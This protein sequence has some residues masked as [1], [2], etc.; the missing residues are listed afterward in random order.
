MG[1]FNSNRHSCALLIFLLISMFSAGAW[2]ATPAGTVIRNPALATYTDSDGL[3]RSVTSN[4]VETLVEQVAGMELTSDQQQRRSPGSTVR[5]SHRVRNTGNADDRF[6]LSVSNVGG[7]V[8]LQSLALFADVDGDGVADNQTP[9]A[10]TPFIA[11]GGD[12]FVVVEGQVPASAI[13][14][15]SALIEIAATSEFD[16]ATT[17]QNLDTVTVGVGPAIAVAKTL[18][19]TNGLSPSGPY[20]VTLNYENTGDEAAGDV[21]L[22]DALPPGMTYVPGSARWSAFTPAL[23]DSDPTDLHVGSNGSLRYCAYDASCTG[24][25]EAQLDSDTDSSN[26]VTAIIDL[27]DAGVSGSVTFDVTID[28]DLAAGSLQNTAEYEYDIAINTVARQFSNTVVFDVLATAGVVANGS[29]VNAINGLNEPVSVFS[30]GQGAVVRFDNIIWNTG[31]ATDT[32]NIE[33]DTAGS[34]FPPGTV[35]QLLRSDASSVMTDT[36]SDGVVDTGPVAVGDFSRV[37]L[38]LR[39]PY[40]VSGN[41]NGLGFDITKTSRSISDATVVDSVTDHLDEIV[42]NTVDV[43]NVAPAGSPGASGTGPGPEPAPVSVVTADAANR[44]QIDVYIRHQGSGPD[45]YGLL[46]AGSASGSTLPAGWQVIFKDPTTFATITSTGILASGESR[47]V[48][49]DIQLPVDAQAGTYSIWFEAR[50]IRTAVVDRKHDAVSIVASESLTLEPSLSAQLEPGGSVVYE[51]LL[52]NKGNALVDDIA[53]SLQDSRSDWTSVIY[54]DTDGDGSYSPLDQP[55]SA[56]LTLQPGES[57]DLF[58]KVF[59]PANATTLQR[60]TSTLTASWNAQ[61][62]S[63][64]VQDQSTVNNSRVIIRKEQ[65]VDTGCD[66]APDNPNDFAQAE[67]E[68]APG[69]NCVVYRLTA[70]NLGLEPSFNVKIHDYTPAYT[71]YEAAAVCSRTPCWLIE[72]AQGDVGA[73]SAETDQLLPGDSFHLQFVVRID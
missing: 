69:N 19:Q 73:I 58:V 59:A 32:F 53:L 8:N 3:Q 70:R 55:Y 40:A 28:S 10:Q 26:Q 65:A 68:V 4:L 52:V 23:S 31:N 56:A 57:L 22:I 7:S 24:I 62:D 54:L 35:W 43:T 17:D 38:Q 34:T 14:G 72:P 5:F 9:L 27:V 45:T 49:A 42:A 2:S 71:R 64:L 1:F 46:A 51:H 20:T 61:A 13:D 39:L 30:A 15:D 36:N 25:A 33:V 44:A 60:N 16:S 21:T 37:V 48:L 6:V 67:L 66:G 63:V 29:T 41:N 11:A 50:S 18:S 12:F 47:H